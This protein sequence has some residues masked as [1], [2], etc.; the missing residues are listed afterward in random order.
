MVAGP[1]RPQ[2]MG[3]GRNHLYTGSFERLQRVQLLSL[4]GTGKLSCAYMDY[5]ILGTRSRGG[6]RDGL[7]VP[8]TYTTRTW[9]Q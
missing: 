6:A 5:C 8:M 4:G 9:G 7:Q 3:I 1:L 2:P